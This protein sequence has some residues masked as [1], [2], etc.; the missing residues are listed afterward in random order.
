MLIRYAEITDFGWLKEHD[1]H[2][3]NEI[4][5]IKIENKEVY[6]ISKK[7]IKLLDGSDTTYFGIIFHL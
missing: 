7:K 1:K 4:L 3:S 6:I 2:I 5:K